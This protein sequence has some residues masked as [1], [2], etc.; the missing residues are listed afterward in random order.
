MI[1]IDN[2]FYSEIICEQTIESKYQMKILKPTEKLIATKK[3]VTS[4][5]MQRLG[6][7]GAYDAYDLYLVE[8]SSGNY[9]LIIFMELHYIFKDSPQGEWT[10]TEKANFM[11]GFRQAVNKKWG[12]KQYIKSLS[13]G[14]NIYLDIRIH[15]KINSFISPGE[16]WTIKVIKGQYRYSK[17]KSWVNL[18]INKVFL[19]DDDL[20]TAT[21]PYGKKQQTAVH[22]F[23]H[24]LGLEDEYGID[25]KHFKDL[26]S[27]MH[28]GSEVLSGRHQPYMEH[29]EK[30]L[31]DNDIE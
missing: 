19:E 5:N 28:G 6:G 1:W 13:G 9:I 21:T 2:R 11:N 29:L 4:G 22:E 25:H 16:N 15:H 3:K 26:H 30:M 31:S 7:Q 27:I 23:G 17:H 24:M 18:N 10:T 14:K 12:G 8:E 20:V